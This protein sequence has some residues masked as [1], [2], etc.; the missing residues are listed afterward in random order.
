MIKDLNKKLSTLVESNELDNLLLSH[1]WKHTTTSSK[2]SKYYTNK[3]K[4]LHVLIHPKP[5]DGHVVGYVAH[6]G[7]NGKH[8]G[9]YYALPAGPKS[10]GDYLRN[11]NLSNI[12]YK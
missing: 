6:I 9:R 3:K 2:G 8:M 11:N 1:G 12:K 7:D 10:I 4:P 5:E